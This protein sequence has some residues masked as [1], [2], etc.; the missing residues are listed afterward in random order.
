MEVFWTLVLFG[1][2][3]LSGPLAYRVFLSLAL[4]SLLPISRGKKRAFV[5]LCFQV[6]SP[7]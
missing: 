6:R 1:T 5:V 2:M 3:D 4:T 7:A